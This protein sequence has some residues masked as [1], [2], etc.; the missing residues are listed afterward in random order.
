MANRVR[1]D[2]RDW[3]EHEGLLYA[4]SSDIPNRMVEGFGMGFGLVWLAIAIPYFFLSRW[5]I[6]TLLVA[7][8]T[9]FD[10]GCATLWWYLDKV[11]HYR[12]PLS[13]CVAVIGIGLA[14]GLQHGTMALLAHV[15]R[16][17]RT[18]K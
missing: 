1:V 9:R 18:T 8:M 17:S 4:R 10:W 6:P 11:N 2:G 15:D 14:L 5:P 12:D 13:A 3:Y 16:A 7:L